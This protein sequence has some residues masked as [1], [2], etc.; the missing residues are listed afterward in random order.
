MAA[1]PIILVSASAGFGKTTAVLQYLASGGGEYVYARLKPED[2]SFASLVH[3]LT[4]ALPAH[5]HIASSTVGEVLRNTQQSANSPAEIASWLSEHLGGFEGIVAVDDVHVIEGLQD[6][7][8][9][10]ARLIE[11][12]KD[13][14]HWILSGRSLVHLPLATWIAYGDAGL[15][16]TESD[17]SLTVDE[18]LDIARIRRGDLDDATAAELHRRTAGWPTAFG[19]A[20]QVAHKASSAD[21]IVLSAQTLTY[22]YLAQQVFANFDENVRELLLFSSLLPIIDVQVMVRAGFPSAFAVM[23]RLSQTLGFLRRLTSGTTNPRYDCHDLFRD[24]LRHQL[25]LRGAAVERAAQIR[26]AHALRDTGDTVAALHVLL[27]ASADDE[28]LQ[29]LNT[30]GF[31]L[32]DRGHRSLVE[33]TLG[34]MPAS[35]AGGPPI[36]LALLAQMEAD[37]GRYDRAH[38][39]FSRAIAEC[40]DAALRA[41]LIVRQSLSAFPLQIDPSE[42]LESAAFDTT[43]QPRVRGELLSLLLCAYAVHRAREDYSALVEEAERV[44]LESDDGRLRAKMLQRIGYSAFAVGDAGR[45]MRASEAAARLAELNGLMNLATTANGVLCT[46][47]YLHLGDLPQAFKWA[48]AEQDSAQKAGRAILVRGAL[49][50]QAMLAARMGQ[51]CALDEILPTFQGGFVDDDPRLHLMVLEAK[52]MHAAWNGEFHDAHVLL[53]GAMDSPFAEDAYYKNGVH[54]LIMAACGL[55]DD[56]QALIATSREKMQHEQCTRPLFVQYSAIVGSLFDL[57]ELLVRGKALRVSTLSYGTGPEQAVSE[58]VTAVER[59]LR[60][61]GELSSLD[62]QFTVLKRSSHGGLVLLLDA[63]LQK[64]VRATH[65]VKLTPLQRSILRAL[66]MGK[67]PKEI[68]HETG[69]SIHTVRT[70]IRRIIAKFECSGSDQAIRLARARGLL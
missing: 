53:K 51:R 32:L 13:R 50:T 49:A 31:D 3:Q 45:A 47:S 10:L 35:P 8:A 23:E 37:Q 59:D 29:L 62:E 2:A 16:L 63:V 12:T 11:L 27:Q 69:S 30:E 70:H 21:S 39:L 33:S 26:A 5:L 19:F 46:T 41:V 43:L 66:E 65:N 64:L 44:A 22:Q 60:R 61:G 38:A 48:Q 42:Q 25:Q 20:L 68:A 34:M 4:R 17:L 1:R 18:A 28:I 14:I 24:F 67:A 6:Q 36:R 57:T 7:T 56:A 40:H 9:L 54:A 55:A 58:I 15:P 52:A